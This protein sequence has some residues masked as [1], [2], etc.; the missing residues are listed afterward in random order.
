MNKDYLIMGVAI[1]GAILL[2]IWTY[3][4]NG[5]KTIQCG[6]AEISPDFTQEMRNYCRNYRSVK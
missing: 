6:L 5:E 1:I 4:K 2:S 3:P